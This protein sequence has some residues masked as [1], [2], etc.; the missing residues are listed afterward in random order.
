MHLFKLR[1]KT[2]LV[3]PHCSKCQEAV[4]QVTGQEKPVLQVLDRL[5][6]SIQ[7]ALDSLDNFVVAG[8]IQAQQLNICRKRH[9]AGTFAG[10][11]VPLLGI[12]DR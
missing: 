10:H 4:I 7:Y 6:L 5:A 2:N 8:Q 9:R 12:E 3:G 1:S 11:I